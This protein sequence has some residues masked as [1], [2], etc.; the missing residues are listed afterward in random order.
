M[1]V[2]KTEDCFYVAGGDDGDGR[3]GSGHDGYANDSYGG[4]GFSNTSAESDAASRE[5][6]YQACASLGWAMEAFAGLTGID[7][8][9]KIAAEIQAACRQAVD[10]GIA[11][12]NGT[13]NNP[14]M[15]E[16]SWNNN[17]HGTR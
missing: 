4:G 11:Y 1:R 13:T 6:G 16:I 7:A 10:A 2:L 17:D 15:K 3:D 12:G 8:A 5:R 9:S 14:G